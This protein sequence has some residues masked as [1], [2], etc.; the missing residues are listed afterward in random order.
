MALADYR[1]CDVCGCKAFYDSNLNYEFPNKE[2]KGSY[3]QKITKIRDSPMGLDN[4]GDWV[5]LCIDC[6]KTHRCEIVPIEEGG[7]T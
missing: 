5:V 1:L 2:G 7:T 4:L 3:N 6:A